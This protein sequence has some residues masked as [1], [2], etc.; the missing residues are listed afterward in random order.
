MVCLIAAETLQEKPGMRRIV[1]AIPF[2]LLAVQ[3]VLGSIA[4]LL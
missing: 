1:L 3:L 2:F 4:D